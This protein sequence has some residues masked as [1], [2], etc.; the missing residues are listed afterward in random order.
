TEELGGAL[1]L[2]TQPG[3]GT[4]FM[5]RLPLTLA[6]ADALI[7]TVGG[8]TFAIPQVSVREVVQVQPGALTVLE[9]NE[10]IAH[11]GGVLPLLRLAPFFGLSSR[12]DRA[13]YA[14]V[15]SAGLTA[16]GLTVDR[17]L[18]LREIVVRPLTDPLI[19]VPGVAGATELGDGR[20]I[21]ILDA[22]A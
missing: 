11:H 6:I 16:V 18:G 4:H 15:V 19:R 21:L 20:A 3:R 12:S 17:V 10:L 5:V 8:Q 1:T 13:F 9:N 14:L 22:M 7:V 2:A